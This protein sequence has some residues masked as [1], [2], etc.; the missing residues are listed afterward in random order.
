MNEILAVL[1][2]CFWQSDDCLSEYFESDLFFCFT[3]LMAEIRDGFL[4]T[5]DSESTGINGKIRIFSEL[6]QKVD[7][8]LYNHLTE[9]TVNPQF[10]SLRWLMLLLSQEFE[11]H[12]VI[13]LWDTLLA[14]NER[15]WFMNYVC[16]AMVQIKREAILA[17]DFSECMEALQRQ[18]QESDPKKIRQLLD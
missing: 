3:N 1:Y 11:I 5:M 13:R 10:Y 16:V 18:S 14:D 7:P 4:R 8:E 12:N 17:G 6:M 15:F 9:Q 2:Y